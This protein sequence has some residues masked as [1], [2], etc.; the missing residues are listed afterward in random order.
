[1]LSGRSIRGANAPGR[2]ANR[3]G[4]VLG[5]TSISRFC[6]ESF[7]SAWRASVPRYTYECTKCGHSY[8]K[9]EGWDAKP[10]QRCP[11]CRAVSQRIPMAPMIVFKGSG[12]YSTD[13]KRSLRQG[14]DGD[15]E[16]ESGA[17]EGSDE[18]GSDNGSGSEGDSGT[19]GDSG[20][21][22]AAGSGKGDASAKASKKPKAGSK[23]AKR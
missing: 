11:K 12:F 3:R 9:L 16:G 19:D 10:R 22:S 15:G 7:A 17:G 1:M 4:G 8:E 5:L 2:A 13:N 6:L 14:A 21:R 23:A 18:A 20:S